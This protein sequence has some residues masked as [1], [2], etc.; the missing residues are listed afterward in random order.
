MTN[1]GKALGGGGFTC[2]FRGGGGMFFLRI[3]AMRV[4]DGGGNV[5]HF[6]GE[7]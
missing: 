2:V 5:A 7:S 1:A 6:L 3:G 4:V